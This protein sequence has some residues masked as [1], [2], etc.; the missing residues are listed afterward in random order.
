M[1]ESGRVSSKRKTTGGPGST[2]SETL[3]VRSAS[4]PAAAEYERARRAGERPSAARVRVAAASAGATVTTPTGILSGPFSRK[5]SPRAI[6][7]ST[8]KANTQKMASGSRTNSLARQEVSS[9]RGG[10]GV[11]AVSTLAQLPA[12]HGHEE[13][14]QRRAVR[15]EAGEAGAGVLDERQQGRRRLRERPPPPRTK[16]SPPG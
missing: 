10:R 8:G 12:R 9:R 2:S 15:G 3:P 16:I 11:I 13:V 14:L 5:A 4:R 1:R 6:A 7:S